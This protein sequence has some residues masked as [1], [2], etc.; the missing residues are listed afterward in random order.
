MAEGKLWYAV[1]VGL[2]LVALLIVGGRKVLKVK[3]QE[4][5]SL[6]GRG[7][8]TFVLVGTLLATW[9]GTGSIFGYAGETYRR[10]V[11]AF[12]LPITSAL[13]IG[14]LYLVAARLRRFGGYTVQDI[15]E[16][17]FGPATRI[18]GTLTLVGAYVII[19]S[20]QY[21]AGAAVLGYIYPDAGGIA[22]LLVAIFVIAYTAL[23][24][25]YS[26][27]HTD[28]ASGIMMT[29]GVLVAI[30]FLLSQTGGFDAAMESLPPA[31]QAFNYGPAKLL[32]VLLPPLLLLVG[33]ANMVQRFFS[34]KSAKSARSSALWMLAG[35]LVLQFAIILIA[36]LASALAAQGVIP[37]PENDGH[38]VIHVAFEALPVWLGAMMIGAVV[39]IIVSTADSYL[40]APSTAL[41]RDV[42]QRFIRPDLREDKYVF[43]SRATVIVTGLI[44]LWLATMSEKFFDVALFA[45]TIY[46]VGITPVLLA[47]YFWPRATPR[48]ALSSM[49][50]GVCVA[51]L[52]R[53][54]TTIEAQDALRLS[55]WPLLADFGQ[56][57]T[58]LEIDA[59]IPAFVISVL[60]LIVIS[61]AG[62]PPK[63]EQALAFQRL[64]S[65]PKTDAQ[66]WSAVETSST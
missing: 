34:A 56:W 1:F 2:Y 43:A 41:V 54:L 46:G 37:H 18:L 12:M 16:A 30:P 13:G 27:A 63:E 28:V 66:D 19:V 15:L 38:I 8:T 22:M 42:Y 5:F 61:L 60:L 59:V 10:G 47:A 35:V 31:K 24:G 14:L 32:S 23:A 51:L 55:G 44:A 53:W 29:I 6:A 40:L 4:D 50:G 17:R 62:D 48:A 52:W 39:A 57:A 20:Y 58:R 9:I 11:S 65:E 7:L 3:S 64:P 45:Y 26:V 33:D 36:L 49:V 25:M 21:R